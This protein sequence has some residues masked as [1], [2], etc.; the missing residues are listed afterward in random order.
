MSALPS[1]RYVIVLDSGPVGVACNNPK[2]P[3]TIRLQDWL[4]AHIAGG[5]RILLPEI[6]DYE[7]R[8]EL[9]HIGLAASVSRLDQLQNFLEYLPLSTEAMR[10]AAELWAD[11]RRRGVSTADRKALDGDVILAAQALTLTLQPND[12]L[13]VATDNPKHIG[14]YVTAD[15]WSNL[16]P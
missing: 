4:T 7:V 14:R 13:F 3:E 6:A 16:T 9:L 11:A 12:S 2:A 8:R 5:A 10:K 15:L 1:L